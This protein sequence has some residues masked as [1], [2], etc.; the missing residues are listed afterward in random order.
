MRIIG[1]GN[2]DRGDDAAG[3][4]A[5]E[6]LRSMGLDALTCTDDGFDLLESW[7]G[8][9]DVI[10]IDAVSSGSPPGTLHR[11]HGREPLPTT[12]SSMSSH[13]FGLRDAIEVA[14]VLALL[15]NNLQIWGIEGKCFDVGAKISPEVESA[16]EKLVQQIAA[17][18]KPS[19]PLR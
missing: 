12:V 13:G 11:W 4:L 2:P 19:Q 9:H 6:R 5:A 17:L 7:H 14:R 1:Y 8:A 18:I 15:P 16:V 10:I 3:P